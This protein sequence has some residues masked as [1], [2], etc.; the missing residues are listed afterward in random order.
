MMFQNKQ[1]SKVM[2]N[3]LR[4]VLSSRLPCY[5]FCICLL[6]YKYQ[7]YKS[8]ELGGQL[9]I[10]STNEQTN[11]HTNFLQMSRPM[12]IISEMKS[13]NFEHCMHLSSCTLEYLFIL[14]SVDFDP[15]WRFSLLVSF[16]ASSDVQ[17]TCK[18]L[19]WRD[20]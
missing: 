11:L 3:M 12:T 5:V 17:R 8:V 1:N 16:F 2:C 7:K 18:L 19:R 20:R 14:V 10:L 4:G 15:N 9:I 6:T 13:T